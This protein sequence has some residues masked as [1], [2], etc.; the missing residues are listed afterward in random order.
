MD[1]IGEDHESRK[2]IGLAE[3]MLNKDLFNRV[4]K[5]WGPLDVDLFAARHNHQLKRDFSYRP[6]PRAEVID[7]LAQI[8]MNL[9]LYAFPPFNLLGRCLKKI[10]KERV[11]LAVVIAPVWQGQSWYP[12]LLE[13]LVDLPILLPH[14][15]QILVNPSGQVHPLVRSNSLRL[16]A[17]K[18][19]GDPAKVREFWTRHSRSFLPRGD[20]S[21][22]SRILQPGKS[23]WAGVMN[24]DWIPFQNL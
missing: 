16:A 18:V 11:Q 19:S 3:W 9:K 22:R 12:A 7:A 13:S 2:Q 10:C 1:N 6:D 17:W 5:K 23:G 15:Q 20:N 21:Q 14:F 8:W 24:G 4:H